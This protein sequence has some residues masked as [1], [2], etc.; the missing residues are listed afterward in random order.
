MSRAG[1]LSHYGCFYQEQST[2]DLHSHLVNLVCPI[3]LGV[4][5]TSYFAVYGQ[6]RL[7]GQVCTSHA[8]SV[9]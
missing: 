3:C 5:N 9:I 1:V 6:C 4:A 8:R 2:L 7:L